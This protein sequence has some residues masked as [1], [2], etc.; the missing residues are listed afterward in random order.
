MAGA[1]C[2]DLRGDVEAIL[3]KALEKS[4]ERRYASAAELALRLG[5]DAVSM[6]A[7]AVEAED[8]HEDFDVLRALERS[9]VLV[10][11]RRLK[12]N[13]EIVDGGTS[14]TSHVGRTEVDCSVP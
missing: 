2:E 13:K 8:V 1:Y 12:L 6:Q 5:I 11:H 4:P 10:E 7:D 14:P 3:A 9:R